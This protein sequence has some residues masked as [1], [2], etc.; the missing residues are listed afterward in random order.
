MF[1]AATMDGNDPAGRGSPKRGR[2]GATIL[3]AWLWYLTAVAA[4]VRLVFIFA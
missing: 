4:I 1:G 3:I 2:D